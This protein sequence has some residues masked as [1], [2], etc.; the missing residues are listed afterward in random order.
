M[1]YAFGHRGRIL[2]SGCSDLALPSTGIPQ[3][4]IDI[5]KNTYYYKVYVLMYSLS[6]Y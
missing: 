5:D 3:E 2:I 1:N 6:K 4:E